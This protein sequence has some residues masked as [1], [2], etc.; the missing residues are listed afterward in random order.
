MH[1]DVAVSVSCGEWHVDIKLREADLLMSDH[2][3]VERV[4][5]PAISALM[6]QVRAKVFWKDAE[7]L[8]DG[9]GPV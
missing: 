9:C 3:L 6:P 7:T 1:D 8:V 4:F 5:E 2:E